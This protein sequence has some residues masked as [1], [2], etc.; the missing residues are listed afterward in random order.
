[1]AS[2]GNTIT[3]GKAKTHHFQSVGIRKSLSIIPFVGNLD[4]FPWPPQD[5]FVV[6]L[7]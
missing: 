1:M 4:P 3:Q 6:T 2:K 5:V 7:F